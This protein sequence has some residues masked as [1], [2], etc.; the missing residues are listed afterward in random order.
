MCVCVLVCVPRTCVH[1]KRSDCVPSAKRFLGIS[2]TFRTEEEEAK[3][4]QKHAEGDKL[5]D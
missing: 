3:F 5:S 4:Q 1:S 2:G